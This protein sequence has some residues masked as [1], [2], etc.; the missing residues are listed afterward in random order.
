MERQGSKAVSLDLKEGNKM[1]LWEAGVD[2]EM[3]R[4]SSNCRRGR[5]R[6]RRR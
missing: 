4:A 6:R 5:S 1:V 3:L 2:K